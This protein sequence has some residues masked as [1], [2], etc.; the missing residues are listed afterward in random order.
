MRPTLKHNKMQLGKNIRKFLREKAGTGDVTIPPHIMEDYLNGCK[1]ALETIFEARRTS[2]SIRVSD[3]GKDRH[4]LAAVMAGE[5]PQDKLEYN[6]FL[7]FWRGYV[8]E[9]LVE[10]LL[11]LSGQE[12]QEKQKKITITVDAPEEQSVTV[13]GTLDVV[14]GDAVYDIKT[15]N[16]RSYT[17]KFRNSTCLAADDRY[18]YLVQGA[19]YQAGSGFPFKGWLVINPNTCQIKDVPLEEHIVPVMDNRYE[20]ALHELRE[21]LSVST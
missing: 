9:A 13:K 2:S 6:M 18:N 3:L 7:I 20:E 8:F 15:A 10:A 5:R 21:A 14:C 12:P 4:Y 16:D 11:E 17:E 19:A 1:T